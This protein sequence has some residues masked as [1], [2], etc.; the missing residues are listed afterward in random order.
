LQ[1]LH[2]RH[3][4]AR[5]HS[6]FLAGVIAS[7]TANFSMASPKT[8]LRPSDFGLG[9]I[10]KKMRSSAPTLS[11]SE[12]VHELRNYFRGMA[13]KTPAVEGSEVDAG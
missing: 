7:V 13:S 11:G 12:Q 6:D 5:E 3:V 10:P 9:P 1:V 8:P 4:R 2:E